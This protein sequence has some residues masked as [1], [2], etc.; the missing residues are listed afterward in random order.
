MVIVYASEEKTEDSVELIV[1]GKRVYIR[2]EI[3]GNAADALK[4][5]Q[6][7]KGEIV[8]YTLELEDTYTVEVEEV[9]R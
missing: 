1:N 8:L 9:S 2:K 5:A 7:R 4:V 3:I 6:P